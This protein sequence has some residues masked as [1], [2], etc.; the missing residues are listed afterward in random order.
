MTVT[1]AYEELQGS[2]SFSSDGSNWTG[3][4]SLKCAFSD[5]P[6]LVD[7]LLGSVIQSPNGNVIYLGADRFPLIPSMV[8]KSATVK[9]FPGLPAQPLGVAQK[10]ATYNYAQVDVTY[11]T[12]TYDPGEPGQASSSQ[13]FVTE[14]LVLSNQYITIGPRETWWDAAKTQAV[15]YQ[16]KF[17]VPQ[18][19]M[20]Y[21][22][23]RKR[24]PGPLPTSLINLVGY[25]NQA[26]VKS[27]QLGFT[28]PAETLLFEGAELS[29]E[30]V[31]VNGGKT[32]VQAWNMVQRF[33]Y[34]ESGWNKFL[35]PGSST[36][37][38]V[39]GST[40]TAIKYVQTGDF[41]TLRA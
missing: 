26:S 21:T 34:K 39:Y 31:L 12:P 16:T 5:A 40:G 11:V 37:Q 14:R 38:N 6:T 23:E 3:N 8:A 7:Q 33:K 10:D 9:P 36:Y 22:Y 41:T 29:R 1:V 27:V 13:V 24:Y 2:P 32:F 28:F 25:T 4:R 20:D 19:L 18:R 30:T 17:V 35:K 15:D